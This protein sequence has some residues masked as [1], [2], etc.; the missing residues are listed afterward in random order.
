MSPRLG[1]TE[2]LIVVLASALK[3]L[4]VTPGRMSS[5]W[6]CSRV[7]ST[8]SISKIAGSAACSWL[9]GK[10]PAMPVASAERDGL[11]GFLGRHD[12]A[13]VVVGDLQH[14]GPHAGRCALGVDLIAQ[15]VD[16]HIAVDGNRRS[17]AA[18]EPDIKGAREGRQRHS[19]HR[20]VSRRRRR[21]QPWTASRRWPAASP[22]SRNSRRPHRWR[23]RRRRS[24]RVARCCSS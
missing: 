5:T 2:T 15:I 1:S 11:A 18:G 7:I 8:P 19:R 21:S 10:P 17:C 23:S 9:E 24:R 13:E 3:R 4:I 20:R 22:S 14:T 16:R 6:F 12:E